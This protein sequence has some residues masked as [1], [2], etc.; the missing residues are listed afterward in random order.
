MAFV[1]EL[2]L[3]SVF[4]AAYFLVVLHFL[5]TWLKHCFDDNRTAYA[6]AALAL[7]VGQGLL[8]ELV[9]GVAARLA[10]RWTGRG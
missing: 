7:I 1:C 4:V 2:V 10:R 6:L 3:Y 8:L 9:T 5:G